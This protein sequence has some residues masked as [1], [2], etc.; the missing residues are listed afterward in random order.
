MKKKI[1]L[2]R[3]LI[4]CAAVLAPGCGGGGGGGST[5]GGTAGNTA[6]AIS[7]LSASKS[8]VLTSGD[9]SSLTVSA[10]DAN[11]DTLSYSW[12]ATGGTLTRVSNTQYTFSTDTPGQYTITVGVSDGRGG[13]ASQGTVINSFGATATMGGSAG[14]LSVPVSSVRA[15]GAGPASGENILPAT[16]FIEPADG[17]G[18]ARAIAPKP[19]RVEA[20][21][22]KDFAPGEIIVQPVSGNTPRTLAAAHGL[23]VKKDRGA[24]ISVL[25]IDTSGLS[26]ADAK[27]RTIDACRTLDGDDRTVFADLNGIAK[28]MATTPNDPYYANQ[29]HYP[30]LNLPQAWD[31]T[32]GSSSVIVAVVDTGI[33]STHADIDGKL[34]AGYDFVS[35]ST[36]ACDGSGIDSNPEDL[37]DSRC[38]AGSIPEQSPEHSGY[39][40]THVAGTIGAESNN[41]VGVA[42]VDWAARIMPVRVL[43]SQGGYDDDILQGLLFAARQANDSGTLPA[44]AADVVNVSIGGEPGSGCP[45]SYESVF[46]ILYNAGVSVFVAAGNNSATALN[47]LALCSGVIAVGAVD[48]YANLAP[49]SNSGTGSDIVAPGGD[50]SY[51]SD[52]GVLSTIRNDANGT[53]SSYAYYQGTS[54][55]TP[56]AAGVA[57]LMYAAYPAITPAQ[58]DT[59]LKQ[60]ATDLGSTGYDTT[61]GYGLIN[62]Y[63]AVQ[64]AKRLGTTPTEPSSPVLAVSTTRLYFGPTE[65]T[66]TI[67]ITNTGTGTLSLSSVTDSENS[68]GNWMS[69]AS[70]STSSSVTLTVTVSRTSL[71]SG[72]YTGDI[73]IQSNGGNAT[74]SVTMQVDAPTPDISGTCLDSNIYVL[75]LDPDT[76]NTVGQTVVTISGGLFR[77]YEV[78][79]GSYYMV[80]GTDCDL[81]DFICDEDIDFCG[82][83][84]ILTDPS[85]LDVTAQNFTTGIDFD[86]AMTSLARPV[87][88]SIGGPELR[89]RGFRK[90]M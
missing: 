82:L 59:L 60:T 24:G 70:S 65:T 49:Y 4:I 55:A 63:E 6:P 86:V 16:I 79:Q 69:V 51:T 72:T 17:R 40:G 23:S 38:L 41:G 32:T 37:A 45:S 25:R 43:G 74:V 5:G 48:R 39:H 58:V 75:A 77:M 76:Y 12:T 81:N 71:G 26:A 50:T 29:W 28:S 7:S 2:L 84:P 64:E 52:D 73:N 8:V 14:T 15:M 57:A 33:V 89:G 80:A 18:A 90:K 85:T 36:N 21:A 47:P 27:A 87:A 83:Y 68:G 1:K 46:N 10:S 42:G 61:Y 22:L 62:A 20:C 31:V 30:Q 35:D 9:S 3:M 44:A 54:M 88:S 56:H 66:K 13:T 78:E 34:T 67:I 53:D 11:G 19:V